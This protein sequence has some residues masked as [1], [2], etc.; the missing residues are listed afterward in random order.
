MIITTIR[1]ENR[2]SFRLPLFWDWRGLAQP[3]YISTFAGIDGAAGLENMGRI[4]FAGCLQI[5][6]FYHATEHLKLLLEALWG[7]DHPNFKKQRR[8]WTGMLLKDGVEKIIEQA[9][10]WSLQRHCAQSVN[11]ALNYFEHNVERMKYGTCRKAGYFIGSGVV[12]AGC[13]TV[14][15]SRCKQSGM[16]WS[17]DRLNALAASN[18]SLDL[19]A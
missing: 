6:D 3:P 16:F 11:K 15:G 14:I 10:D 7:K 9:R 12:E 18:D 5:V 13:K 17:E 1:L 8:R 2:A 19:A 4:N